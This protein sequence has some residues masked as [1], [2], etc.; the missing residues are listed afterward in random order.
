MPISIKKAIL[1]NGRI[2]LQDFSFMVGKRNFFIVDLMVPGAGLEPARSEAP[3]DFKSFASAC[4]ATQASIR[5][6]N[7]IL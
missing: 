5:L 1:E 6:R 4:S 3:K 7:C 2:V